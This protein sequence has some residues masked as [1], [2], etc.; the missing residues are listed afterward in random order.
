MAARNPDGTVLPCASSV[1]ACDL[2]IFHSFS[3]SFCIGNPDIRS[4]AVRSR[5]KSASTASSETSRASSGSKVAT[6]DVLAA[7]ATAAETPP[8][9]A[10]R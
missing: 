2:R 10:N 8:R 4:T 5:P 6:I 7:F 1:A 9:A 3:L